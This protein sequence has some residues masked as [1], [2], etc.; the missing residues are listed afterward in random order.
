MSN[1]SN[2]CTNLHVNRLS[3]LPFLSLVLL[4]PVSAVFTIQN[5]VFCTSSP[6]ISPSPRF[7]RLK[8]NPTPRSDCPIRSDIRPRDFPFNMGKYQTKHNKTQ[9]KLTISTVFCESVFFPPLLHW[10]WQNRS[11]KHRSSADHI[12]QVPNCRQALIIKFIK[13]FI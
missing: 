9:F 7:L 4:S 6:V 13:N 2:V 10:I 11:A 5:F 3:P 1:K 12:S 8:L